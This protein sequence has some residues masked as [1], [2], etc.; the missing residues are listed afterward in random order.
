MGVVMGAFGH[1]L[2]QLPLV[3][4]SD[5][6]FGIINS[7]DWNLIKSILLVA[8]PR[9]V[10]LSLQQVVLL[11]F[12]GMATVMTAGS[13]SVFQLAFNLQSVP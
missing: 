12:I 3:L 6:R 4:K 9:A 8:I 11:I 1:M 13:V 7:I 10:T 2:V 5:L